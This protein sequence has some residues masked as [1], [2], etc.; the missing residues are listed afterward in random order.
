M[1]LFLTV[2]I[3]SISSVLSL[4]GSFLLSLKSNWPKKFILQLTAFSSGVLLATALLHLAPEALEEISEAGHL[5]D[6]FLVIF[7]AIVSFFVLE[8]LFLWHHHHE[9]EHECCEP[10]SSAYLIMISDTM[11]N[12]IDGVLIAGALSVD[13]NLG[14]I[15]AVAVAAHEIP[16]EIADFSVM[17]A[18]GISRKKALLFNLFSAM[19]SVVGAIVSY[20]FI[21]TVEGSVP[22]I[23][24]FSAGMFLY[25]ALADLVPELHNMKVNKNQKFMQILFFFF[26]ILVSYLSG[27][28]EVGGH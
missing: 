7:A 27:L 11:H 2:L 28:L 26:G 10:K 18:G 25:I 14:L 16:Q 4:S 3:T 1:S 6:G 12:F 20:F 13:L 24:A 19:S 21:Q 9:D 17:V 15:T 8:K 23:I 22:Y 5:E